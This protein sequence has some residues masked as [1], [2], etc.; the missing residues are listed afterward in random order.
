MSSVVILTD[1]AAQCLGNKFPGS[2]LVSILPYHVHANGA[3]LTDARMLKL[4][5]LPPTVR[6][7][8][9]RVSP[10]LPED[11][12]QAFLALERKYQEIVVLLPSARLGATYA[13]AC[14]AAAAVKSAATLHLIDSGNTAVGL[15]LMVQVAAE[16]AANGMSGGA[17]SRLLR[18]L[19]PHVYSLFCAQGLTYLARAGALDPAQAIAGEMLGVIPFF[20]LDGGGLIPIQKARSS[21]HLLDTF[22][23]FVSEFE[24]VRHVA[25]IEGASPYDQEGRT[26][27]ERLMAANS[28]ISISEHPLSLP[29]A[30]LF[31]PRCLG[32]AVLENAP[33]LSGYLKFL[34]H[35]GSFS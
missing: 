25:V 4:G 21:R 34:S 10:P 33:E 19:A 24:C 1:N 13:N 5:L 28:S 35:G 9:A 32:V 7:N 3:S 31:G 8:S 30:G 12:R 22:Y 14:Q 15:G 6:P 11:F 17:I 27:R 16:A 29:V 18:G 23:E 2:D 26:L 20:V